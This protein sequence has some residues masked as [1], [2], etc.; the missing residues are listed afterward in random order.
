MLMT[1]NNYVDETHPLRVFMAPQS[2][3]IIPFNNV[4]LLLW[5]QISP[6]TSVSDPKQFLAMTDAFA[7][8]RAYL[9]DDPNSTVQDNGILE[10]DF[11]NKTP[12]DQY[13]I[14]GQLLS[15]YDAV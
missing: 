3:F 15:L 9:Q 1:L 12:W 11:S 6:P 14:A 13:R 4:L 7:K 10:A 8:G 2:D 5:K